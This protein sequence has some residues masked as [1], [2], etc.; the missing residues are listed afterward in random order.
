MQSHLW[1]LS[2]HR[3][4]LGTL[5]K[6]E[7][8]L[9]VPRQLDAFLR[10]RQYLHAV[11]VLTATIELL[12][13]PELEGV[14]GLRELYEDLC[15]RKDAVKELLIDQLHTLIYSASALSGAVVWFLFFFSST[16]F[17]SVWSRCFSCQPILHSQMCQRTPS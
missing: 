17:K 6:I 13:D 5:D 1:L 11:Y 9:S 15:L 3:Q 12:V 8:V 10:R 7:Y 2:P 16:L 4:V 14:E